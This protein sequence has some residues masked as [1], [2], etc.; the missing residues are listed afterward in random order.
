MGS[1]KY[2]LMMLC[3]ASP[4]LDVVFGG[5]VE[6][7][8]YMPMAA[9]ATAVNAVLFGLF[10]L[11]RNRWQTWIIAEYNRILGKPKEEEQGPADSLMIILLGIDWVIFGCL[12]P[13]G[14]YRENPM[15]SNWMLLTIFFACMLWGELYQMKLHQVL[16]GT[17]RE[18]V[19]IARLPFVTIGVGIWGYLR[20]ETFDGLT[21]LVVLVL[22]VFLAEV[23]VDMT[24]RVLKGRVFMKEEPQKQQKTQKTQRPQKQI[25][26]QNSKG[27]YNP[28]S[29]GGSKKGKKR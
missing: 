23:A 29:K 15:D 12:V 9:V 3:C 21:E 2:F 10:Y 5:I 11:T 22:S 19:K 6:G 7:A 20:F 1:F 14:I 26:I 13:Y 16:S 18:V 28:K 4:I 27:P 8:P 25:V 24:V 17:A